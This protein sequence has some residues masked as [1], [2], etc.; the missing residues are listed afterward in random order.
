MSRL[1]IV[2]LVSVANC[3]AATCSHESSYDDDGI[4]AGPP[5]DCTPIGSAERYRCP[6]GCVEVEG[7]RI[8]T[9]RACVTSER[10]V[11][12]CRPDDER[13]MGD[14]ATACLQRSDST[15]VVS[16][17]SSRIRV[18]RVT[19]DLLL[20]TGWVPCGDPITEPCP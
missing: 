10:L 1:G 8:D 14:G 6:T 4:D 11:I 9:E 5:T 13:A 3:T 7:R 12:A 16:S 18:E 2:F 20:D 19:E 17:P 15:V